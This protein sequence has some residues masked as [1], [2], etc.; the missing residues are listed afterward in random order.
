MDFQMNDNCTPWP[1][2]FEYAMAHRCPTCKATP[3]ELCNAPS[4][5]AKYARVFTPEYEAV[6][7]HSRW[8][9]AHW[10]LHKTRTRQGCNQHNRDI[11]AAPWEEERTRG[12]RYDSLPGSGVRPGPSDTVLHRHCSGA[13]RCRPVPFVPCTGVR[14]VEVTDEFLAQHPKLIWPHPGESWHELGHT[15]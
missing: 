8:E 11:S 12:I 9:H 1:T 7:E 3:G 14:V 15:D 4:N 10:Q 2:I 6:F 13:V 5:Q